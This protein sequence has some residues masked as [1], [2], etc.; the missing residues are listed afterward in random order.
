M[1]GNVSEW[2]NDEYDPYFYRSGPQ[3][4]PNGVY[5]WGS[6]SYRGGNAL[7][8][9]LYLQVSMRMHEATPNRY[10]GFR[11]ARTAP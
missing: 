7:L 11:V 3:T 2:V 4:D 1:S 8:E 6:K 5:S 9:P 10:R